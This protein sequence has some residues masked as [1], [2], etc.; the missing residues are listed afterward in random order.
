MKQKLFQLELNSIDP[1][2]FKDTDSMFTSFDKY[3]LDKDD[4]TKRRVFIDNGGSVLFV[5]HLDTVQTP[6]IKKYKKDRIW[7]QG[8][9]DRL[10]ACIAYKLSTML[11]ADLLLTDNEES[12]QST[13]TYHEMDT[14]YNWVVEFDRAGDD[15]VTYDLHNKQFHDDLDDIWAVGDG[16]F[17]DI[18]FLDTPVCCFNLGIGYEL[19]HS[20]DSW[21]DLT[22]MNAQIAKFIDFYQEHKDTEYVFD[23][24][25]NGSYY[26]Q[27]NKYDKYSIDADWICEICGYEYGDDCH[28]HCIC[29][30]CFEY[31][32]CEVGGVPNG[33]QY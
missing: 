33:Q 8:L 16:I 20:K 26:N 18:C 32:Y 10:G 23:G 17:S 6:M 27:I 24:L 9:D 7:A 25:P 2:W 21:A 28:G 11:G 1:F 3:V 29:K 4:A 15:V 5:A 30:D 19:S 22:I 31:M 14:R 13:A 12:G